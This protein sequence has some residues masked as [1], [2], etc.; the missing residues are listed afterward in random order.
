MDVDPLQDTAP[1]RHA[2]E[3]DDEEDEYNPAPRPSLSSPTQPSPTIKIVGKIPSNTSLYIGSGPA[4]LAWARGAGL[5]EQLGAVYVN[6]KQ[7]G[8]LFV[9]SWTST[10]VL[11]SE[12]MVR[13]PL[14]AMH[15]YA[16]AVLNHL[17][18]TSVVLLDSYS[19]RTYISTDPDPNPSADPPIRYLSANCTPNLG[20]AVHLFA[21]PNLLQS[22]SASFLSILH[23]GAFSPSTSPSSQPVKPAPIPSTLLLLPNPQIP[24][25]APTQLAPSSASTLESPSLWSVDTMRAV[26]AL[27]LG[28]LG[29]KVTPWEE[30]DEETTGGA[31]KDVAKKKRGEVGEGGMYI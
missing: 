4:G 25:P 26:H 11:M 31:G 6:E 16:E 27:L 30:R 2:L 10:V 17:N 13:L 9:P 14:W 12:I 21:L 23:F 19:T 18:P 8:L 3:S 28:V 1:P 15:T 24:P 7:V 20:P 5:G 29:Q 22:T